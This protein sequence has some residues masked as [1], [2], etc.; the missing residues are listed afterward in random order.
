LNSVEFSQ[1]SGSC[2]TTLDHLRSLWLA[3][4]NSLPE[5]G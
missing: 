5:L 4:V 2:A 1:L 3:K